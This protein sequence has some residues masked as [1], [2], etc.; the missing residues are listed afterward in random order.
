MSSAVAEDVFTRS[1]RGPSEAEA[2][3]RNPFK[4]F[5]A[6]DKE[7]A[8]I[9]PLQGLVVLPSSS[10]TDTAPKPMAAFA[11]SSAS[12]SVRK[13]KSS[14]DEQGKS[15]SKKSS[16]PAEKPT[17]ERVACDLAAIY[18]QPGLEFSFEELKMKRMLEREI[19]L[20]SWHTWQWKTEWEAETSRTGRE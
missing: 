5:S 14:K 20:D 19:G 1:V 15:K 18:P 9:D 2:L 4:N 11:S 12:S 16:A 10:Q 8:S 3:R 7:L 6:S 13:S 17:S